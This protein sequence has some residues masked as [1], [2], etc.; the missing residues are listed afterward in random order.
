MQ[1]A[2][3]RG[4][5]ADDPK[6]PGPSGGAA[7]ARAHYLR[8]QRSRL[9]KLGPVPADDAVPRHHD[10]GPDA[11]HAF[12]TPTGAVPVVAAGSARGS[13]QRNG[14][15]QLLQAGRLGEV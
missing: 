3:G 5:H 6:Q 14:H 12:G 15:P 13:D 9:S 8:R 1:N 10:R 4:H 7:S 11:A 2:R